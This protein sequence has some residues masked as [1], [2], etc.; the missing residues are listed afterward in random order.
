MPDTP[1]LYQNVHPLFEK[2]VWVTIEIEDDYGKP[3]RQQFLLKP[4]EVTPT[5]IVLNGAARKWLR[6]GWLK[7]IDGDNAPVAKE[8]AMLE[9]QLRDLT[10]RGQ[11]KLAEGTGG[12]VSPDLPSNELL[13]ALAHYQAAEKAELVVTFVPEGQS[14]VGERGEALELPDFDLDDY[15]KAGLVKLAE[16]YGLD[17]DGTV[18]EIKESLEEAFL[19]FLSDEAAE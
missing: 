1:A 5:P 11:Q 9:V 3:E 10:L 13:E 17:T 14:L 19:A 15:S 18:S 2:N 16:A 12:A 4:Y 6:K 8:Q 7:V